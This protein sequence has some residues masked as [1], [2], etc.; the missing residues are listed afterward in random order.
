MSYFVRGYFFNGSRYC[1]VPT[2]VQF[3]VDAGAGISAASDPKKRLVTAIAAPTRAYAAALLALGVVIDSS[4]TNNGI[5]CLDWIKGLEIDCPV[6]ILKRKPGG[7]WRAKGLYKGSYYR[8]IDGVDVPYASIQFDQAGDSLREL[9]F[10]MWDLIQ[11]ADFPIASMPKKETWYRVAASKPFIEHFVGRTVAEDLMTRSLLQCVIVGQAAALES[12]LLHTE[13]AVEVREHVVKGNLQ[14]IV[15]ARRFASTMAAFRSDVI[16]VDSAG[17]YDLSPPIAILDGSTAYLKWRHL[18]RGSDR[19]IVLDR[20][21]R[22]F[23]EAVRTLNDEYTLERT[24]EL[25]LGLGAAPAGVE[26][27]AFWESVS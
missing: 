19:I 24:D 20:A 7:T 18:F 27:M 8:C 22:N 16:P 10:S 14:D 23:E 21:D 4:A 12:E 26:V 6:F 1:P 9:P 3:Y 11:E 2:W 13:F 5:A 15:R 25:D 17:S